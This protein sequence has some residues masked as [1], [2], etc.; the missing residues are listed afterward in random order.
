M[1]G[2]LPPMPM[3]APVQSAP[4]VTR[5]GAVMPVQSAA[6]AAPTGGAPAPM[7]APLPA[8]PPSQ[9]PAPTNPPTSPTPQPA[10]ATPAAPGASDVSDYTRIPVE[11]DRQFERLDTDGALRAT[12]LNPSD[13]WTRTATRG[14]LGKA[15]TATISIADQRTEKNR[16]FDLLDALSKSGALSIDDASLHVVVAA[17]HCF[18]KTLLDT[19]IQDN[20]NPIEKVER[21][22]VIVGTTIHGEPASALLADDQRERFFATSPQLGD[23]S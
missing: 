15:T 7:M 2:G 3:A 6:Q 5:S 1:P 22:L 4:M 18:D 8:P 17:T 12:I 11:L 23:G 14:L 9:P 16:A 21:S 20:V 10:R 19:V 13:P